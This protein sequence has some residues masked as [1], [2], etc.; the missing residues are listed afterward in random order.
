MGRKILRRIRKD[1]TSK[2]R[3]YKKT[4]FF[5]DYDGTLTPI[6]E[7]PQQ[8]KI[9]KEAKA[10]LKE[11]SKKDWTE[12]F[13]LSGRGLQDVKRQLGIKTITYIGNHGMEAEGP[14]FKFIH[15]PALRS[16]P[17]IQR[18]YRLLKK[19]LRFKGTALEN[20]KYTLSFHYRG[21]D[22]AKKPLIKRLFWNTISKVIRTGGDIVITTGKEVLEVRPNIN[23]NKGSIVKWLLAKKH[24]KGSLPI[25]IGDDK[26]D[27]DAF[28]ALGKKGI[29]I[30]VCPR[31][32]KTHAKYRLD[33]PDE[34]IELLDYICKNR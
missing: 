17:A 32:R 25:C 31:K 14:G 28:K 11:I 26:T 13:I 7:K 24:L 29:S 22:N 20:K 1:L 34:V 19:N 2:I 33:S 10:L 18:C 6:K 16:R 21:A 5:L 15:K 12:V 3:Q 4:S 9:D 27:E 8:A 23:W 30:L